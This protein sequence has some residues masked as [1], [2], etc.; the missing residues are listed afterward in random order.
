M[1][2]EIKNRKFEVKDANNVF[3]FFTLKD[4]FILE[5]KKVLEEKR[6]A[7]KIRA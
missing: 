4:E 3:K 7:G 1:R 5:R 2:I 6:K